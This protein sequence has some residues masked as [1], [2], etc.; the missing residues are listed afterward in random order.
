MHGIIIQR[1]AENIQAR[2]DQHMVN[3]GRQ[4]RF[5]RGGRF[6]RTVARPIRLHQ[7]IV[8]LWRVAQRRHLGRFQP[9]DLVGPQPFACHAHMAPLAE[10]TRQL[11]PQLRHIRLDHESVRCAS[12]QLEQMHRAGGQHSAAQRAYLGHQPLQ[13]GRLATC[14][15]QG[16]QVAKLD[17]EGR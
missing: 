1:L 3:A 13:R 6:Q 10:Q 15:D 12:P 2:D 14:A 7:Q 17:M 16:D 9:P 11:C 5:V 4:G 8:Q